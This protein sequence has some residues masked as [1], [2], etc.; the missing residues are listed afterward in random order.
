MPK[1][2]TEG[3]RLQLKV[4]DVHIRYEDSATCASAF[5]CG[6]TV[7]SLAAESCDSAWRRGF[8]LLAPDG[9]SFKLL[10]LQQLAVYWDPMPV[11]DGIFANCNIAELTVTASFQRYRLIP[12]SDIRPFDV[13]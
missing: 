12:G 4:K 13:R 9:C 6:L 3:F 11:P 1:D 2:V 10:E 8:S 5:A 7:A